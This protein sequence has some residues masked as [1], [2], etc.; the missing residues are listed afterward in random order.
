MA[1]SQGYYGLDRTARGAR[2]FYTPLHGDYQDMIVKE[3]CSRQKRRPRL[4][5]S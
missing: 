4:R 3:V 5:V 2:L 1:G